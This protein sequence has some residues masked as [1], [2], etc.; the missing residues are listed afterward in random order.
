MDERTMRHKHADVA[1]AWAD[2]K[3]IQEFRDGGWR[4]WIYEFSPRFF[5]DEEY[6][7]K[8]T[9]KPDA[10]RH[11]RVEKDNWTACTNSEGCDQD[12]LRV[13]FDGETGKL[14]SAEVL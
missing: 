5:P 14:K 12:N 8:P 3:T 10:V 13:T 4:D 11:L 6:R 7:I 9:P 2:G 1:H